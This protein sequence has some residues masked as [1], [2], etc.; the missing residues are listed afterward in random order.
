MD[1]PAWLV[2]FANESNKIEG[3]Q[4]AKGYELDALAAFLSLQSVT[5]ADLE[6][7]VSLV[8]PGHELR[9][10]VGLNVR[11]GNHIAPPGGPEIELELQSM[12]ENIWSFSAFENHLA[13]ETLHPFSDGNGRSGRALWLWQHIQSDDAYRAFELGFLHTFYYETLAARP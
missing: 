7:Y 12:L 2:S 6:T 11:V 5:V 3:M 10:R 4:K 13:Y 9:R 1:R 8:A